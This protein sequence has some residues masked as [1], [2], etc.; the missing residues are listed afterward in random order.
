MQRRHPL[1]AM[2][3]LLALLSS[4][5]GGCASS[6]GRQTLEQKLAQRGYTLGKEVRSIK[7]Y[8]VNGWNYIDDRHVIVDTGPG[9]RH[10]L[11]L[12]SYCQGLS[13]AENLGLTS[14]VAS[15]IDRFEDV[16]LTDTAG[17]HHRCAIKAVHELVKTKKSG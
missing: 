12:Y 5:L 2:L 14:K 11:T 17:L 6:A 10:L 3:A 16:I 9:S 8:T 1:F 15:D 13:S 7:S 4:V